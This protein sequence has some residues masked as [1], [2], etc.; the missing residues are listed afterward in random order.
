MILARFSASGSIAWQLTDHLGSVRDLANTSGQVIDHVKYDSFGRVLYE[1]Q[2]SNGDRFKYTA[3]ELDANGLYYY[4]ARYLD[5][6]IG[7]FTREDPLRFDAGDPNLYRYVGNRTTTNTDPMGERRV[8]TAHTVTIEERG[9]FRVTNAIVMGGGPSSGGGSGGGL[10]ADEKAQVE[11]WAKKGGLNCVWS[12]NPPPQPSIFGYW[13]E[14]VTLRTF[15]HVE[16]ERTFYFMCYAF[17]GPDGK[18]DFAMAVRD[19]SDLEGLVL[20]MQTYSGMKGPFTVMATGW[21]TKDWVGHE[22][23]H[24]QDMLG[25]PGSG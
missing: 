25:R 16:E 21:Y 5:A 22:W 12:S 8:A 9:E 11:A 7:R 10:T 1:S 15:G 20:M 6:A 13:E 24:Y 4:R 17:F 18:L 3:R 2:P 19:W 23:Y 14:D